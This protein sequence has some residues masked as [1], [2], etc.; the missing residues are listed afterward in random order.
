VQQALEGRA[1]P[2]LSEEIV[3]LSGS[4]ALVLV[5]E[6]W[7]RRAGTETPPLPAGGAA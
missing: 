5:P 4:R 6:G 3:R 2:P 7:G 1:G